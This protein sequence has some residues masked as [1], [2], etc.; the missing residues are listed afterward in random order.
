MG[1]DVV[2]ESIAPSG[3]TSGAFDLIVDIA[4]V[5]I[6]T[7]ANLAEVFGVEGATELNDSAF[8]SDGLSFNFQ[9]TAD[10]KVKVT[11]TPEG[12]PPAFFLRVKVK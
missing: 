1:E 6:G 5:E 11:A 2:I 9:R 12:M 10:G 8:S 3:V 4:G 7:A